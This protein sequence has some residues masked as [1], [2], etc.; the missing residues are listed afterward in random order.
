[1]KIV[2]FNLFWTSYHYLRDRTSLM[3]RIMHIDQMQRYL[4]VNWW[5]VYKPVK[6]AISP[7]HVYLYLFIV[8][9][10][11]NHVISPRRTSEWEPSQYVIVSLT[12]GQHSYL[13]GVECICNFV[14]VINI[15]M[16]WASWTALVTCWLTANLAVSA[17]AISDRVTGSEALFWVSG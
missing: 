6:F 7:Q 8:G 16:F 15:C 1:M 9:T 5:H 17:Q 4:Q 13:L 11:T 3:R 2:Y 10:I 14:Q 12:S